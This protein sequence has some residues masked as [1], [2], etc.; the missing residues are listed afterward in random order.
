MSTFFKPLAWALP[1]VMLLAGC[2]GSDKDAD[3]DA[4]KPEPH[5]TYKKA[6]FSALPPVTGTDLQSGFASW[7]SAC[8]RLKAD[9]NWGSV[10]SDAATLSASPSVEQISSF[11]QTHLDVY[12]LRSAEGSEDGLIT[13]YYEPV[14]PGSLKP[15]QAANVPIYGVPSDLIVVNLDSIYPELK[16]K[17]LRGRLEGRVLKPYDSA[18]TINSKGLNAPVLAWLTDPMDL[19]FLQIQGSGRVQLDNGRQLR[20]GYA[21]QNGHPY[22]PIGR[23]LV[24]QGELK[25]EDVTMSTIHAWAMMHPER[26]HEMLASNPSYVFFTQNPDSTEGP[27][28]SLNVPLTAGYSVAVDRKVIPLGSLLWL[29]TTQADGQPIVRPVAAQDTGG[30]IAGEVRADFFVGTGPKAGQIAGDMK[31]KGNIWLLWPKDA[32]LPQ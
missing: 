29:S 10:C 18:E 22:K 9:P 27:R 23:W 13:G 25:K 6:D 5:T 8:I 1:I 4:T 21:D 24:E 14:Y 19:Q 26:V 20:I 17:R 7:R 11:L 28:G 30:A 16:G 12:S 32:A 31:Q 15:T 2:N 3:K